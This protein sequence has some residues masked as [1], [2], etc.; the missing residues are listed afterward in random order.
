MYQCI[1]WV[2]SLILLIVGFTVGLVMLFRGVDANDHCSWCHY[3]SCIPTLRWSCNTQPLSCLVLGKVTYNGHETNEFIPQRTSA[4]ISQHDLH[5]AEMTVRETLAFSASCQ[6]IGARYDMMAELSRREKEANIKTDPDLDV[7]LKILRLDVCADTMVGDDMFRGISGGQK[8]QS[9]QSFILSSDYVLVEYDTG[10][11][12][13]GSAGALFM[14]EISTGLDSSTTFQIV[15]TIRQS[16]H[17]LQGI[18]VISLLQP[19]P[20]TYDLFDDIILLSEGQIV[21]QGP[22]EHVLDFF[23]YMGFKCPERKGVV[24]YLQRKEKA[25]KF[26]HSMKT[27][28]KDIPTPVLQWR[29]KAYDLMFMIVNQRVLLLNLY[30]QV[31]ELVYFASLKQQYE[32]VVHHYIQVLMIPD[33]HLSIPVTSVVF[34]FALLYFY[35][36]H[37]MTGPGYYW[38]KLQKLTN[39]NGSSR[40]FFSVE[41]MTL[42]FVELDQATSDPEGS[43]TRKIMEDADKLVSCLVNKGGGNVGNALT[44]VA[45]L[46][47]NPR[48]N[49]KSR[50]TLLMDFLYSGLKALEVQ[51]KSKYGRGISENAEDSLVPIVHIEEDMFVLVDDVLPLLERAALEPLPPKDDKGPQNRKKDCR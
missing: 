50:L 15:N 32:I 40:V 31:D 48:L 16:A 27:E 13:V 37:S 42:V 23:Q 49:L 30:G 33:L 45:H 36:A 4:Y 25:M 2:V 26:S 6:G 18:V 11:M 22:R 17:I 35:D 28:Q 29:Q 21:Y 1:F 20:E 19:A 12:L 24:D 39:P 3:L 41:G 47:L 5:I 44:C 51:A 7:F 43:A 38:S 34:K 14:D 10:E 46:G 9:H 8:Q